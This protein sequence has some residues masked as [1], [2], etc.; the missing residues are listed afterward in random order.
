M[1]KVED[2]GVNLNDLIDLKTG[3]VKEQTIDVRELPSMKN[4]DKKPKEAAETVF[5]SELGL[6]E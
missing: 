6:K 4:K 2:L 3:E 5:L 1:K